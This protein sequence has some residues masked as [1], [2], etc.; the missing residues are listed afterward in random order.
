MQFTEDSHRWGSVEN[1]VLPGLMPPPSQLVGPSWVVALNKR[2][3]RPPSGVHSHWGTS[4]NNKAGSQP[5]QK[6]M[7]LMWVHCFSMVLMLGLLCGTSGIWDPADR[8][9]VKPF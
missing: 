7:G 5:P 4:I 9:F 3:F 8:N 2:S 6:V 1:K